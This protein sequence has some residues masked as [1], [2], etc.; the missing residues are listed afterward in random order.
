[1]SNFYIFIK[2]T[3]CPKNDEVKLNQWVTWD[4]EFLSWMSATG[5][6]LPKCLIPLSNV[7]TAG[8]PT[9]HHGS[10]LPSAA[11]WENV[12]EWR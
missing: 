11:L 12:N 5:L 9:R 6:M 4:F 2:V 3:D 8:C 10:A 7:P 1:M